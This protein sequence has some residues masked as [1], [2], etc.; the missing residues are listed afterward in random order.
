VERNELE[1]AGQY[2]VRVRKGDWEIEISAPD[3]EFVMSESGNLMNQFMLNTTPAYPH[4]AGIAQDGI[5]THLESGQSRNNKPQTLNE[6]YRQFKPQTHL[7]KILLLGYW[8][9]IKLGQ[10]FF[11]AE[12]ILSKYREVK[13]SPPANI[14]RDLGSLQGKGLLL[15]AGKNEG[16]AFALTNTGIKEVESKMQSA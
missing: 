12:E 4:E 6:F 13:E 11:T 1:K 9:E 3:K 10:S 7:E 14:R 5:V 15:S 8:C 2:C 16:A